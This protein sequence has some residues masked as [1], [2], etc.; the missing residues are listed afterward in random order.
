K[1]Q[2]HGNAGRLDSLQMRKLP[3]SAVKKLQVDEDF[4]YVDYL[5]NKEKKQDEKRTSFTNSAVFQTI[6]WLIII[7][8]FATF[9]IIYLSNSNVGLFRRAGKAMITGDEGE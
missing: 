9:V 7:A 5:F 4:W 3:D 1:K 6:L 8:G 2:L